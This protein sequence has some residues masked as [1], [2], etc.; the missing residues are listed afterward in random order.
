MSVER[1][2]IEGPVLI[3]TRKFADERGCFFESY[4]TQLLNEILGDQLE[5]VQDNISVS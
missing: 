1:F 2:E 5:F 4:N 3:K